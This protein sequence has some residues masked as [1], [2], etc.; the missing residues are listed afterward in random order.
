MKLAIVGDFVKYPGKSLRDFIFESNRT[1]RINFVS[2]VTQ[3][4]EVLAKK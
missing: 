3:A 1:G 2:S 4:K